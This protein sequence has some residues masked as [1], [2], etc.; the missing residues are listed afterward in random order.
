[1]LFSNQHESFRRRRK[2]KR[3]RKMI[4]TACMLTF[5]LREFSN[6]QQREIQSNKRA[7]VLLDQLN[8]D[9]SLKFLRYWDFGDMV[10]HRKNPKVRITKIYVNIP[11]RIPVQLL[12][13]AF[14]RQDSK[15]PNRIATRKLER[16]AD[17][18]AALFRKYW[19]F[20]GPKRDFVNISIFWW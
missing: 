9:I 17:F 19:I 15:S 5:C 12:K 11:P 18:K 6:I 20:S 2:R 3:R 4:N 14:I 7:T 1:M 13:C 10:L 16:L 8:R